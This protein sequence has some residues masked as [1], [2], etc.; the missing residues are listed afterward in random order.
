MCGPRALMKILIPRDAWP[1][2]DRGVLAGRETGL[3]GDR[4][5]RVDRHRHHHRAPGEHLAAAGVHLDAVGG[6]MH[7]RDGRLEP[8]LV[9]AAVGDGLQQ[10][11][12]AVAQRHPAAGVLGELQAA[13]RQLVPAQDADRAAVAE[14]AVHHGLELGREHVALLVVELDL[15][16]PLGHR[17]PVEALE[18]VD[19][20][21]RVVRGREGVVDAVDEPV[22]AAPGDRV[23]LGDRALAA[24]VADEPRGDL[25]VGAQVDR[26]AGA[27]DLRPGVGLVP[28]HPAAAVLDVDALPGRRPGAAADAIAGLQ[29]ERFE[30]G[31]G[32]FAS[33][34]DAGKSPADHDN[35]VHVQTFQYLT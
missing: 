14:V 30:A 5:E 21:Q 34:G 18:Q 33:G 11:V 24:L 29:Q 17:Q 19:P 4:A 1:E 7:R 9:A 22:P 3:E 26:Q 23:A 35:V 20:Q 28:V 32:G 16:H 25:G 31:V 27:G 6:L 10:R 8:A 13:A 12:G 15:L 2:C